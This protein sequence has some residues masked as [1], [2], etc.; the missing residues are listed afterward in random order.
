MTVVVSAMTRL[1]ACVVAGVMRVTDGA[2]GRFAFGVEDEAA[3]DWVLFS[4]ALESLAGETRE[5]GVGLAGGNNSCET[6]MTTSERNAAS[7][8]RLSIQGTGS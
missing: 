5:P 3:A 2:V 1:P 6:A 4:P 7:I 8:R